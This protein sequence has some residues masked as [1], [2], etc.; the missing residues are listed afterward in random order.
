MSCV[1][2][3]RADPDCSHDRPIRIQMIPGGWCAWLTVEGAEAFRDELDATIVK[4]R[5]LAGAREGV[6]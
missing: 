2:V 4:I 6:V 5:L 3:V 1:L